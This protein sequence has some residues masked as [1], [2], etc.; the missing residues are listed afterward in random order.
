MAKSVADRIDAVRA[1]TAK[2][3]AEGTD[4]AAL[5]QALAAWDQG[6]E[7]LAQLLEALDAGAARQKVLT[8]AVKV[9]YSN[10][11]EARRAAR[12]EIK[13]QAKAAAKDAKAAA[14][15]QQATNGA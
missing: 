15:A 6:R 7:A 13:R 11:K 14:R 9:A 10:A 3:K 5:E 2:L 8:K 4:T 1:Y 12:E